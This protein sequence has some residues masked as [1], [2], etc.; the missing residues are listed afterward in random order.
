V[1][2]PARIVGGYRSGKTTRLHELAAT[3]PEPLVISA[4]AATGTTWWD[5]A[6]GI[7]ER[8]DRPVRILSTAEV[9]DRMGGDRWLA[10]AVCHYA[11]SFLGR[12][13]LR[14][15]AH[16]AGVSD[17]WEAVADAAETYLQA[18]E[19]DW[20]TVLVRASL[21][22]RDPTVLDAERARF[23]HVLVDDFESASFA[24]TRLLSQ[25]AGYGGNVVV[26][27]NPANGVW[28]FVAGSTRYLDRFPR[29]FGA[30]EDVICDGCYETHGDGAATLVLEPG[31]DP[32]RSSED[33]G[34]PRPVALST[35][36]SWASVAIVD[37]G[38]PDADEGPFDLDVLAGPDVPE[39]PA[40]AE[41]R[42]REH[43]ARRA[44]AM[45]RGPGADGQTVVQP[46]S[47]AST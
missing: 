12:E 4:T 2:L 26:A 37:P 43:P 25:L 22:L 9:V 13:E 29:R 30:V 17:Q 1:R 3:L 36:R 45:S 15:H 32:W 40:R 42:R 24:T 21:L 47:T 10:H 6:A 20:A 8:H 31:G 34:L 38:P 5:V 44:L 39:A 23:S 35:S 18:N 19:A 33:D 16:A 46:P 7:V 14:T 28:R 27:R 41:R 11:A